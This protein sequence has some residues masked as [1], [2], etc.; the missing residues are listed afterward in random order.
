MLFIAGSFL[1]GEMPLDKRYL[2]HYFRTFTQRQFVSYYLL[3]R[4]TE[5]FTDHTGC[6]CTKKWLLKLTDRFLALEAARQQAKKAFDLTL[7]AKI[8]AGEYE[9]CGK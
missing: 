3:F 9:I 5:N 4:D 1:E 8:E 7:L 6:Y 2:L